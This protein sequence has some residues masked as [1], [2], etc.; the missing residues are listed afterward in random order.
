VAG[1]LVVPTLGGFLLPLAGLALAM[2]YHQRP[3]YPPPPASE[4]A[5]AHAARLEGDGEMLRAAQRAENRARI[6]GLVLGA[7]I[8][9]AL[10][11]WDSLGRGI[12]LAAPAAALVVALAVGIGQLLVR[13]RATPLRTAS[14][15]PRRIRD[16]A[17]RWPSYAVL[18]TAGYLLA[19]L[20]TTTV[21]ASPDDQ[22]RPGR[23][24]SVTGPSC[25]HS[26]GPWPGS[27]YAAPI[28]LAIVMGLL[29]TLPALR[30]V[31]VRPRLIDAV[32]TSVDDA[33]RRR[34]A[35]VLIAAMGVLI[36]VPA[37]GVEATVAS[38]LT[39]IATGSCAASAWWPVAGRVVAVTTLPTLGVL[40]WCVGVLLR[41]GI[42]E[43][44]TDGHLPAIAAS[45][46]PPR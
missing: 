13:P 37:L 31:A 45:D 18:T 9:V 41:P 36:T 43:P 42:T 12:L 29:V 25:T 46:D 20:I 39:G 1:W 44:V 24:I 38:R 3:A 19:V 30:Y 11:R 16:Y 26:S 35:H 21:L 28:L 7:I 22:G 6:G 10:T 34:A 32:T 33:L 40:V 15:Q 4:L 8:A 17:P 2:R 27:F 14:L 5:G 23:S